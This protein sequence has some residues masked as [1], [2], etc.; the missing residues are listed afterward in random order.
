MNF[1]FFQNPRR[2]H[3]AFVLGNGA[4]LKAG[5]L[6]NPRN[7]AEAMAQVLVELGFAVIKGIDLDHYET[8]RLFSEFEVLLDDAEV[9]LL[10]LAV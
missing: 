8:E 3:V 2:N 1:C 4:Y 6:K 7:D 10:Y 9:A 5:A